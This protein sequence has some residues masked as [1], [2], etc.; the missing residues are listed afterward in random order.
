MAV[1]GTDLTLRGGGSMN[2]HNGAGHGAGSPPFR[3]ASPVPGADPPDTTPP[4]VEGVRG[5]TAEA[6]ASDTV[7]ASLAPELRL[8]IR[9]TPRP[10]SRTGHGQMGGKFL[11]APTSRQIGLVV[12]AW[13]R[14]GTQRF[15]DGP[16]ELRAR[17]VFARPQ[18]HFGTG[19]N[20]AVL[21]ERFRGTRPTG[22]PDL[23]NLVK[24]ICEALQGN[25]FPDDSRIVSIVAEKVYD[26]LPLTEITVRE[27]VNSTTQ[28]VILPEREA[29]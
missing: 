29:A 18:S 7:P 12:D 15:D 9:G 14:A 23:D 25:A 27:A 21:K 22:R 2:A 3:S 6:G 17:F 1:T 26:D 8:L 16:F 4:G 10:L 11:T 5:K 13:E 19:R 24:L 28:L 20:T